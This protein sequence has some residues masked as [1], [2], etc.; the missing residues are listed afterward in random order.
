MN[1]RALVLNTLVGT[2]LMSVFA[3]AKADELTLR[4]PVLLGKAT[5]FN[6]TC[7]LIIINAVNQKQVLDP[8]VL[9]EAERDAGHYNIN[10]YLRFSGAGTTFQ[11]IDAARCIAIAGQTAAQRGI[12]QV[13]VTYDRSNEVTISAPENY[14]GDKR[15]ARAQTT[16]FTVRDGCDYSKSSCRVNSTMRFYNIHPRSKEWSQTVINDVRGYF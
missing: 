3:F 12:Q 9:G 16:E 14:V 8:V 7:D 15:G 6:N 10:P 1:R 2:V 4:P 5:S 11:H 13:I